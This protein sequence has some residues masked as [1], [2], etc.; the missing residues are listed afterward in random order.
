MKT[1][2]T[3]AAVLAVG[4]LMSGCASVSM[5]DPQRD[6]SLKTFPVPA[7]KAAIYVYRN[8][9]F[10]GA[11]KM[12]VTLD[13]KD[14]GSTAA[15]TYLYSE[16]EPGSHVLVSK[17]ENDSVLKVDTVA[18]RIY[19]VWQEVKMG[20]IAARSKLQLVDEKEG[21]DGVKESK[22]AVVPPEQTASAK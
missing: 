16:V 19:Y 1:L 11:I 7:D 3:L 6:A 14:M 12:P 21:Q 8:E 10:G 5:G 20:L 9:N 2:K 18:G 15:K 22:L 13:G 4:A 17:T